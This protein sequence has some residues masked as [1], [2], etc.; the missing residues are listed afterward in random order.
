MKTTKC[1][2]MGLG[3]G[4]LIALNLYTTFRFSQL[5]ARLHRE[6]VTHFPISGITYGFDDSFRKHFGQ[7]G[8]A[9]VERALRRGVTDP[10]DI[11]REL[12]RGERLRFDIR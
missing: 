1:L 2:L 6:P 8:V 11:S 4:L 12:M 10:E 7:D 3:F 5:E 9:T